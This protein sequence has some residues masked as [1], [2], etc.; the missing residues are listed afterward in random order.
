MTIET[1]IKAEAES[2]GFALCG[3]T[4]PEPP[5][6][7]PTYLEWLA[8]GRHA[9]MA[10]LATPQAIA[11][12]ADPRQLLPNCQSILVLA[13]PYPPATANCPTGHGQI[14][15]YARAEDYHSHL[16]K[17]LNQLLDHLREHLGQAVSARVCTDSAPLL[18]RELAQRAGLGWIGRN[19]C[20]IH[21]QYGSYLL[22][23]EILLDL[24]LQPDSPF[25]AEYCGTCQ[26]CL[27]ACPTACILPNRTLD[28]SRC[29]SYLTIENKGPIPTDLRSAIADHVFGCDLCQQAC[30][31][32]RRIATAA[33]PNI[34]PD[35]RQD[36]Q[37]LTTQTFKQRWGHSALERSRRR[38]YLR[39][40]AIVLG[41]QQDP[42]ALPALLHA[43]QHDPEPLVRAHAAW[44][45]A[46]ISPAHP[47][48]TQ[49]PQ[50]ESDPLV[51]AE[52][53]QGNQTG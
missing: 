23:A 50:T 31:W 34:S 18:E 10:Y 51:R 4:T 13:M 48:L 12:R 2:L 26:R 32:N 46:Q 6:S 35:L 44:A 24:P 3:I 33:S 1:W 29:L 8:A 11:L 28:A 47:A 17:L 19:T 38:G 9:N 14:A 41:N 42:N 49:A 21:P 5:N 15:A 53:I 45:I 37:T 39:N 22:L 30:P 52:L 25:K 7:L 43:L 36:L 20:L 40:A 16:P 27:Q